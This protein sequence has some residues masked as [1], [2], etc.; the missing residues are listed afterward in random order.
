MRRA[1]SPSG[2]IS[3]ICTFIPPPGATVT[4]R[5]FPS[6]DQ[7]TRW[8]GSSSLVTWE[9]APAGDPVVTAVASG[10]PLV[11][12][13]T[14]ATQTCGTP[15]RFDT[16]ATRLPSGESEGPKDPVIFAIATIS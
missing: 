8:T 15:L 10:A 4:A 11:T 7:T 9:G 5:V 6:G 12:G 1:W 16:K 2:S 3:Q 14:E 13:S